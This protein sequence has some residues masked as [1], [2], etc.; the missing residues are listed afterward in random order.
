MSL[1]TLTLLALAILLV[2]IGLVVSFV[3]FAL[4]SLPDVPGLPDT[5]GA[6]STGVASPNTPRKREFWERPF[7]RTGDAALPYAIRVKGKAYR[8]HQ[9]D[10]VHHGD[11]F[12]KMFE[13]GPWK[14]DAQGRFAGRGINC[15]HYFG[16]SVAA[17][18][19]EA[20]HYGIDQQSSTLVEVEGES[21]RVLDLT[22]PEVIRNVFEEYV[23]DH[24]IASWSYYQM[25]EELVERDEGGNVLTAYIG[26]KAKQEGY[27][28]TLFYSAGAVNYLSIQSA[29]RNL[30]AYT[31]QF[32]FYEM[33]T[34]LDLLNLVALSGAELLNRIET[35][36]I[37][38]SDPIKNAH[39]N[40]GLGEI[41]RLMEYGD[42]YQMER[43]RFTLGRPRYLSP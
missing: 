22:H 38:D 33:R 9:S 21:H 10:R 42:D 31:Y 15:G 26:Y 18:S 34:R 36:R 11:D 30:E 41:S 3:I 23:I 25:L 37:G 8:W 32:Y 12:Y 29:N 28:A 39:F 20:R 19:D 1:S 14:W 35:I 16:L 17:A 6:I 43:N 24:E 5:S 4:R 2:L 27:E 13:D 7:R 40:R